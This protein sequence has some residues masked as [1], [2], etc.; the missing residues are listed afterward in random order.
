MDLPRGVGAHFAPV[1]DL[2]NWL[3]VI[4]VSRLSFQWKLN[5]PRGTVPFF[6]NRVSKS[7]CNHAD[8]EKSESVA[9]EF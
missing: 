9:G 6:D 5:G 4:I 8:D 1:R 7:H 2:L 3:Q